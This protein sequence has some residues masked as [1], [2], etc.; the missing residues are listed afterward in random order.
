MRSIARSS[1]VLATTAQERAEARSLRIDEP[2]FR[3]AAFLFRDWSPVN[4]SNYFDSPRAA[5][6]PRLSEAMV[7]ASN[8]RLAE[9]Q[10]SAE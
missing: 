2:R 4:G 6:R 9:R 3:D 8:A 1:A 5:R 7:G 10:C